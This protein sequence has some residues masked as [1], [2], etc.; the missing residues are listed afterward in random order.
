MKL[1]DILPKI[2]AP[3]GVTTVMA[4]VMS[5]DCD[6]IKGGDAVGK[7]LEEAK[8]EL[9][10]AKT[11]IDN[12]TSDWSYWGYAGDLA[13]WRATCALLEAAKLVGADNLPDV[14]LPDMEGGVVMD[15]QAKLEHFGEEVLSKAKEIVTKED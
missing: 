10:K 3:K 5:G 4:A 15:I 2:H 7:S 11:N 1:S 12:C 8:A 6:S 9:K 14:P 13:Y